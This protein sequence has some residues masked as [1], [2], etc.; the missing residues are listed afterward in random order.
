VQADLPISPTL[1]FHDSHI[2]QCASYTYI[3]TRLYPMVK[4]VDY[5][6]VSSYDDQEGCQA[7]PRR[8]EMALRTWFHVSPIFAYPSL[9]GRFPL[10][11]GPPAVD[12]V[13]GATGT[14]PERSC[15]VECP[16][17]KGFSP[18]YGW[19]PR[20]WPNALAMVRDLRHPSKQSNVPSVTRR[21]SSAG[22]QRVFR[23]I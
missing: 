11:A 19:I 13:S 14:T 17:S 12:L 7:Q 5:K 4:C 8:R 20:P 16:P 2:S 9:Q 22:N 18:A 6:R 10:I 23:N 15:T 1:R 21:C 3:E